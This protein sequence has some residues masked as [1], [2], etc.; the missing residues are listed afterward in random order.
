MVT[1]KWLG[2]VVF[3]ADGVGW[4]LSIFDAPSP[5]PRF[6]LN[7]VPI[8]EVIAIHDR[9]FP[10]TYMNLDLSR[11]RGSILISPH[12]LPGSWLVNP[13]WGCEPCIQSPNV[14]R[15]FT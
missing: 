6:L 11:V 8:D 7:H 4:L 15:I 12:L 1:M 10:R 14:W 13:K 5:L 2:P 9:P 3:G